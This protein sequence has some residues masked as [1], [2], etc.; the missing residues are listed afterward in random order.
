[1]SVLHI[2]ATAYLGLFREGALASGETI[3]VDEAAGGVGSAT[4]QLA[5]AAGAR[6]ITS[7]SPSDADWVKAC[8]AEAVF[9]YHDPDLFECIAQA[10]PQGIDLHWDNSGHYDLDK[11]LPLMAHGG[12]I[13]A[14]SGLQAS[15]D[16]SASALYTPNA[17]LRGVAISNASVADLAS[18]SALI[19]RHLTDGG[20]KTRIAVDFP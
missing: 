5:V 14:A 3:F 1:M 13:I 18:A 11:T 16:L 8:G 4:V 10:A 15:L 9:D 2:A 20:L 19:N 17:S 6:V 7:A 12:R